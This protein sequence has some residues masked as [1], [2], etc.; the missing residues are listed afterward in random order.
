MGS[1]QGRVRNSSREMWK[2]SIHA[3]SALDQNISKLPRVNRSDKLQ[4]HHCVALCYS[5]VLSS[6]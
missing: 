3:T 5:V 6:V 1:T 2:G 4:C